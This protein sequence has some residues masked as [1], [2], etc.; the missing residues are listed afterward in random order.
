VVSRDGFNGVGTSYSSFV[1]SLFH[2]KKLIFINQLYASCDG[3]SRR[4]RS[5]YS[6][7]KFAIRPILVRRTRIGQSKESVR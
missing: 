1:P 6:H 5:G 3:T 2:R 4:I 7:S